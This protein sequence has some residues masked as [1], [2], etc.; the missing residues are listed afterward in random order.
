MS[1]L[2]PPAPQPRMRMVAAGILVA[3]AV[4]VALDVAGLIDL[5]A[6]AFAF[7]MGLLAVTAVA[8]AWAR[9]ADGDAQNG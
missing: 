5:R 8:Q 9:K 4:G 1:F 7:L 6:N 3:F 2:D